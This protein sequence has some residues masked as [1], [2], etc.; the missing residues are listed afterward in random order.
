MEGLISIPILAG[1]CRPILLRFSE[2][3][4]LNII[5]ID[6]NYNVRPDSWLILHVARD[7]VEEEGFEERLKSAGDRIDEVETL[8]RTRELIV[9]TWSW[10]VQLVMLRIYQF[11]NADTG[12]RVRVII[13]KG[14]AHLIED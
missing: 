13:D 9:S 3:D 2:L 7:V 11:K 6:V 5:S 4:R 12:D 14:G 10:S 8:R 1:L